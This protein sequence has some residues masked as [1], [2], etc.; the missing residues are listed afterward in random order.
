VPDAPPLATRLRERI[1]ADGP[2][3]FDAWVDACLYD[4]AGGFY[5]RG[6][7]LGPGGAFS[8]APMLHP[9]FAAA[10]AAEAAEAGAGRVLEAGPGDGSLAEAL[11]DTGLEVVLLERAEGMRRLQRERLGDRARWIGDVSEAAPFDGLVVANELLDAL[12]F[13]L[14]ADDVEVFVGLDADDRFAAVPAP[15]PRARR[16]IERPALAPLLH[17]LAGAVRRGRL[18]LIDYAAVPG[19]PRD[20]VRTYIGGQHGGDPLQAPGT[21]DLTADVDFA[22]VRAVLASAALT[23]VADEPQAAWLRRRGA[24]LPPLEGRTDDGWRMAQLFDETLPFHVLV[25][26]RP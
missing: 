21:Q 18:L 11:L 25:A 5:A 2:L 9:A 7:R 16:T 12:P 19:D 1:R 8:T 13:R 24:V 4:S 17:A 6:A 14:F 15:P 3:R 10:V 22:E 23:V 20:P 26:V